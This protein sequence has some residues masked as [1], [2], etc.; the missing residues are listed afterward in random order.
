MGKEANESGTKLS[1][2]SNAEVPVSPAFI[3]RPL[4]RTNI[5]A[6]LHDRFE[7]IL[8]SDQDL[9]D[10]AQTELELVKI[11]PRLSGDQQQ[12]FYDQISRVDWDVFAQLP[13]TT[14]P[15][16][17]AELFDA[18]HVC[19]K[20]HNSPPDNKWG[21][22]KYEEKN[23]NIEDKGLVSTAVGEIEAFVVDFFRKYYKQ[24]FKK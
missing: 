7:L 2:V 4:S 9:V 21:I 14:D 10:W 24:E 13:V 19:R 23:K 20:T 17:K 3:E 12:I 15:Q 18:F 1:G 22:T 11:N 8:A 5:P 16:L 6:L